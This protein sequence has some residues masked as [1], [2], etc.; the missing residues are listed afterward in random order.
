VDDSVKATEPIDLFSDG[1]RS[2]NGREVSRDSSL[3]ADCRRERVA[4]STLIPPME[5]D[6]MTLLDQEPGRH[7][8]E[9]IR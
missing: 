7:Q 6:L 4:T 1:P 5:D 8:T 9:P 2:G 3:G